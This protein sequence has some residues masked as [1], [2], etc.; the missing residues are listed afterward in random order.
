MEGKHRLVFSYDDGQGKIT[1]I[2]KQIEVNKSSF[3]KYLIILF[4]VVII[5]MGA[6]LVV[7]PKYRL[8]KK[9]GAKYAKNN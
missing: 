5:L 1:H 4:S 6:L 8:E 7:Y 2:T 9:A 3:I